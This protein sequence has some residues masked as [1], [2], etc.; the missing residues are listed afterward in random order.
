[1]LKRKFLAIG[2]ALVMALGVAAC[3]GEDPQD[4]AAPGVTSS[5]ENTQ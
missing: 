2:F 5:I 1:M 3:E 4:P